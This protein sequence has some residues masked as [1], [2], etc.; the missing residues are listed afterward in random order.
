MSIGVPLKCN[1]VRCRIEL[2]RDQNQAIVT[3][4]SHIFCKNCASEAFKVSLVC[5]ACES[6]L[7]DNESMMTVLLDHSESYKSMILAGQGPEAIMEISSRALAFWVYQVSQELSFNNII[8]KKTAAK[9]NKVE[10]K[11]SS[12]IKDWQAKNK[13]LKEDLTSTKRDLESEKKKTYNLALQLQEKTRHIKKLLNT[14][15]INKQQ[16][17]IPSIHNAA[18]DLV[19]EIPSNTNQIH[20]NHIGLS[21]GKTLFGT[22]MRAR[23]TYN[24]NNVHKKDIQEN[25]NPRNSVISRPPTPLSNVF[26]KPSPILYN[27]P[28]LGHNIEHGYDYN[29]QNHTAALRAPQES[30]VPEFR[31][32]DFEHKFRYSSSRFGHS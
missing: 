9:T 1:N 14:H 4:C 20:Y 32:N 21:N 26:S 25:F 22:E 19:N 31:Q 29:R 18:I 12:I 15:D 27:T 11:A 28:N 16:T 5:P 30:H 13:L 6:S 23:N 17:I 8:L 2:T 3:S 10:V 7:L 24:H